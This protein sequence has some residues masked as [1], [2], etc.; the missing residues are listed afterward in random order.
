[1]RM[2]VCFQKMGVW[3]CGVEVVEVVKKFRVTTSLTVGLP[4]NPRRVRCES[5]AI[6]MAHRPRLP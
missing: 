1:V 5:A 3:G 4:G 6:T 2:A